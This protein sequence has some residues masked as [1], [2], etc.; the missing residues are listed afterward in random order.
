MVTSKLACLAFLLCS[1]AFDLSAN[2]LHRLSLP[3]EQVLSLEEPT[4]EL[5][6]L[7]ASLL[8]FSPVFVPTGGRV[9]SSFESISR[10]F[11]DSISPS[12]ASIQMN[13]NSRNEFASAKALVQEV[14]AMNVEADQIASYK[15]ELIKLAK[16]LE[17][18]A[19]DD[20]IKQSRIDGLAQK[21]EQVNPLPEPLA[22]P[23]LSGRWELLYTT[24]RSILQLDKKR[25]KPEGPIYQTLDVPNLKARNDEIVRWSSRRLPIFNVKYSR[26][27]KADLEPMSQSKVKVRFRKFGLGRFVRIPAPPSAIGE[28]D[29]TYLDDTLRISR[30]DRGNLFI[31]RRA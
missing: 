10:A 6:V 28:L 18:G 27:V 22:S 12:R 7:G 20:S 11:A 14:L 5:Q 23:L 29:T 30:G 3:R 17:R 24:S 21:L 16:E 2:Q 31:L 13:E 25:S 19:V 15:S 4:L 8:A 26:F 9:P 1:S